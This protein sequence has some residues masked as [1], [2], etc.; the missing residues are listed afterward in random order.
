MVSFLTFTFIYFQV[1]YDGDEGIHNANRL[2]I[3]YKGFTYLKGETSADKIN[4]V[5]DHEQCVCK[6]ALS[7]DLWM[8]RPKTQGKHCHPTVKNPAE[9]WDFKE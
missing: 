4:W 5:C 6:G 3:Y 1:I 8:K 9:K 7:T 2:R